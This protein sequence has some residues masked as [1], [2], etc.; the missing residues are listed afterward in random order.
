MLRHV[1]LV[2]KDVSKDDIAPIIRAERIGE[3]GNLTR[4]THRN[5]REDSIL[6]SYHR[7]NL[8]S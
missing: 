4:G 3:L 8:K 1:A 7:E 6:H 2:R 5:I